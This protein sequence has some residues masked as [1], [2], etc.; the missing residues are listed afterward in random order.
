MG[1]EIEAAQQQF[2]EVINAAGQASQL[3]YQ[4][5]HLVAA[6]VRAELS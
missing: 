5:N 2:L 6:V 1:W 4:H 3:I